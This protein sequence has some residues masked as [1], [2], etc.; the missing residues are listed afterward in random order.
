ML[1]GGGDG[2]VNWLLSELIDS[3]IDMQRVVFGAF[4]LGTGNDFAKNLGWAEYQL[5]ENGFE[6]L[7]EFVQKVR[8]SR[9]DDFDVWEVE[10]DYREGG[11]IAQHRNGEERKAPNKPI[12]RQITN[13]FSFGMDARVGYH[14]DSHR[15]NFQF[16]N[17]ILYC[18][19]GCCNRFRTLPSV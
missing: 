9:I 17:Y 15:S 19:I 4:P 16:F 8:H 11:Y 2:T 10:V 13:Y 18:L 12:V 1:A 7:Q 6:Q 14:F 5:F 3:K